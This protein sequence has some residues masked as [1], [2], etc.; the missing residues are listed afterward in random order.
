MF[1]ANTQSLQPQTVVH[2]VLSL[3][4]TRD[5]HS[6]SVADDVSLEAA[7]NAI[8][9]LLSGT[10]THLFTTPPV[11]AANRFMPTFTE[12]GNSMRQRIL[13]F[14]DF[15]RQYAKIS[16]GEI[17]YSIYLIDR[18]VQAESRRDWFQQTS[19]I[20]ESN[21][22]TLLLVAAILSLKQ[23]RDI[24]YRN[25]WW[26]KVFSIPLPVLNQSEI[27]FLQKLEYRLEMQV[28]DYAILYSALFEGA[29]GAKGGE[30]EGEGKEGSGCEEE[31]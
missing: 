15:T 30:G 13:H 20:S 27:V 12:A 3:E 29:D 23:N 5:A 8:C 11:D 2:D 16:T 24:P 9:Y 28:E 26:A 1:L 31:G 17:I 6:A 21:L 18:L 4:A 25:S 19:I 7:T 22:G 10:L 14:F